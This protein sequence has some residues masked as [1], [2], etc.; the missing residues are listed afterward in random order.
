[1]AN[2]LDMSTEQSNNNVFVVL[3]YHSHGRTFY[4]STERGMTSCLRKNVW[5]GTLEEANTLQA[6]WGGKIQPRNW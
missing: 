6:K 2:M 1:M 4:I 3:A 5:C